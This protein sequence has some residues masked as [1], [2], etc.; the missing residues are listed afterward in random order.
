[1]FEGR[2]SQLAPGTG[3][4]EFKA[5]RIAIKFHRTVI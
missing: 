3:V 1:M 5:T 4:G 2:V